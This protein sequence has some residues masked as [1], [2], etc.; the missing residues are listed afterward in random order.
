VRSCSVAAGD[1]ETKDVPM[2]Y[3]LR[4]L[5]TLEWSD[6]P[7]T[8]ALEAAVRHSADLD[9]LDWQPAESRVFSKDLLGIA[10]RHG[11][12][13]SSG[14]VLDALHAVDLGRADEIRLSQQAVDE[15]QGRLRASHGALMEH[16]MP[17]SNAIGKELADRVRETSD[18]AARE[19]EEDLIE[20]LAAPV[21]TELA[22]HW[23]DLGGSLPD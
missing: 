22:Q 7:G 17:G 11:V 18:Q 5:A 2:L 14:I 9:R 15:S 23:A 3:R 13:T 1:R 6:V 19:A 4:P 8:P 21:K 12:A 20:V 10:L 16:L